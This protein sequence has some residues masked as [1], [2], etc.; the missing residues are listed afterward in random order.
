M[1]N[2][3]FL[4]VVLTL[5]SALTYA[6]Q[7]AVVKYIGG[8]VS[9]PVL[10]FIQSIVCLVLI[11]IVISAQG[12]QQ[13]RRLLKT[14]HPVIHIFRTLFSLGISYFLFYSVKFIPRLMQ[15]YWQTLRR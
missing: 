2:S 14:T 3:T 4:G 8:Q 7:T 1:K 9:T 10:V 6:V 13:A 5:V 12:K 15:Y 11:G